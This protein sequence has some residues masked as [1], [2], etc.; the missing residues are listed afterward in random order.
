MALC[1]HADL[2]VIARL[3]LA[4]RSS[5]HVRRI[6]QYAPHH[7]TVPVRLARRRHGTR[8]GQAAYHVPYAQAVHPYPLENRPD[9]CSLGQLDNVPGR[10]SVE[11]P[12]NVAVA[13]GRAGQDIDTAA[14]CAVKLAT[15][16]TLG[17][18][19]P[20]VFCVL[21]FYAKRR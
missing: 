8:L 14:L 15:T 12:A 21:Q 2:Q 7:T 19:R 6:A 11:L 16:V 18:L 17:D 5:P 1:T 10:R 9:R 20:L 4:E 3:R 13:V